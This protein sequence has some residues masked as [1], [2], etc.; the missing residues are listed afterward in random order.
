MIFGN[1]GVGPAFIKNV[2]FIFN[3][4]IHFNSSDLFFKHIFKT[5]K[6]LDT[7]QYSN[8][9][10]TKG[11][12]L[13][14]NE[15]IEVITIKN[16]IGKKLFKDFMNLNKLDYSIIYEDVYGAQWELKYTNGFSVPKPISK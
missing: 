6:G 9:T 5:A 4:S 2:D 7:I 3:D 16:K 1:K 13:P 10:F 15:T 14:A 8:S 11:F 12:V